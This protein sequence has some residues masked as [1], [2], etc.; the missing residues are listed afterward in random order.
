MNSD[1]IINPFDSFIIIISIHISIIEII[2]CSDGGDATKTSI[3]CM[4]C[5]PKPGQPTWCSR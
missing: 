3:T 2:C 5:K 1:C 4:T